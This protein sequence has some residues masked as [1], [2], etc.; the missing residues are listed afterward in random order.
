MAIVKGLLLL[1]HPHLLNDDDWSDWL[2]N[3]GFREEHYNDESK[4]YLFIELNKLKDRFVKDMNEKEV[5]NDEGNKP[6]SPLEIYKL[7]EGHKERI[8]KVRLMIKGDIL[9]AEHHHKPSDIFYIVVR[10]YW[11]DKKGKKFRKFSKNLGAKES[12]MINGKIPDSK[13]NVIIKEL[14]GMM[15]RQY[16]DE[17]DRI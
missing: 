8:E 3:D 6:L 2:N 16:Q 9:I 4:S 11:I 17:Y 5:L 1:L 14:E 13:L 10:A 15:W 7:I 12:V